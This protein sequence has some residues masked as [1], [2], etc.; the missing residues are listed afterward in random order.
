MKNVR[1]F[2][3]G[4]P[5]VPVNRWY[6]RVGFAVPARS[7][8]SGV[9]VRLLELSLVG[10]KVEHQDRFALSAPQLTMTWRGTTMTV[11]VRAARSEIV[12]RQAA[13]LVY[14]T[15]LY[16][17]SPDSTTQAFIASILGESGSTPLKAPPVPTTAQVASTALTVARTADDSWTRQV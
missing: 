8:R 2:L 11:A 12:G 17:V 10:G 1:S 3:I 16:F 13:Q 5:A 9:A 6:S 15:G 4:P 14:H 7:V